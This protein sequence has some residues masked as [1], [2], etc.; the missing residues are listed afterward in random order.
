LSANKIPWN[1]N[2]IAQVAA[3]AALSDKTYL[4]TARTLV[5][6]ERKFLHDNIRKLKLFSPLTSESNYFLVHLNGRNSKQFRDALVKRT[7]V[8][9]RDCSTFTG[10]G[11]QHIRLAV[12]TRRENVL[13]LNALKAFDKN[14]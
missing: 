12:K 8:L 2:A 4:S 6:K 7:G 13:L 14:E 10:M 5:Q 9:V 3:V 11:S 1:I